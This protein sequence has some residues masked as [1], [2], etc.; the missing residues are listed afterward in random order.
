MFISYDIA[1]NKARQ[2]V[3]WNR[4]GIISEED[5]YALQKIAYN[6]KPIFPFP[7][8]L[9]N[10]KRTVFLSILNQKEF[11]LAQNRKEN[12]DHD[13]ITFSLNG[14][15]NLFFRMQPLFPLMYLAQCTH[16]EIFPKSYQ[17][18]PKSSCIY[19]FPIYLE[20]IGQCPFGSKSIEKW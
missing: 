15:G 8:T 11:H 7:F 4:C 3:P 13:H 14:N 5:V 18:K 12:C 9:I 10:D 17:I 6:E 1:K 2:K 16:G 19:H 20:L